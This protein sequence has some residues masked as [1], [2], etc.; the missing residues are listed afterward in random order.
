MNVYDFIYIVKSV[1][2]T[3]LIIWLIYAVILY[4][5]KLKRESEV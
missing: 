3:A 1:F 4:I 5:S 2:E